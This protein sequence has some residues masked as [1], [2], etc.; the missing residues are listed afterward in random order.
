MAYP[1]LLL[2]VALFFCVAV[3]S[4]S[5]VRAAQDPFPLYDCVTPNVSFWCDIYG[6]YPSTQG[7]L[8]DKRDLRVIYEVLDVEGVFEAG[9]KERDRQRIERAKERYLD[10]LK[11]LAAGV[12]PQNREEKRVAGLFGP[13]ATAEDFRLAQDNIRFQSGQKDNFEKG[14][15]RSGAYLAEIKQIMA[16]Y[17]VPEDLA[18]LPH[19]ES[20]FNYKAY[21]KFGAAGIWQFTESSGK[22]FNLDVDYAID[23]RRDPIKAT[24][25]AA[26]M[27]RHNYEL[28]GTWPL[29][30]TAYNHGVNGMMRAKA[31]KGDYERIFQEHESELFKFASRNFYSEFLAAREVAKNYRTYFGQLPI[32]P[33]VNSKTV[34]LPNYALMNDLVKHLKVDLETFKALN[35]ALREP[36]HLGQKLIPKGYEVRVP[37]QGKA[38]RLADNIPSEILKEDQAQTN[39]YQVRQGDTAYSIALTHGITVTDL[40]RGNGLDEQAVICP[41]QNLR[42]PSLGERGTLAAVVGKK[43]EPPRP[44][45]LIPVVPGGKTAAQ[46][47][48]EVVSL[49]KLAGA[50]GSAQVVQPVKVA[51]LPEATPAK[52]PEPAKAKGAQCPSLTPAKVLGNLGIEVVKKQGKT[53][54]VVRVEAE[55][56]LG[57]YARWLGVRA[58]DLRHFNNLRYE[59]ALAVNQQIK[60]PLAKGSKEKFEAQRYEFHKEMVEDFFAA[61]RLMEGTRTYR[62][63]QGDTIW[64]LCQSEFELPFWLIKKYNESVDFT[65][66]KPGLHLVVPRV[67]SIR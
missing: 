28:L 1:R 15:I 30:V 64:S 31:A 48:G 42:I 43:T 5:P 3:V 55:E 62:V 40:L 14:L 12:P 39:M 49:V 24:H 37:Q 66:L 52:A 16:S 6:K 4:V 23:E 54:G 65:Q 32:E 34:T 56:T 60:I 57:H 25:A 26:R 10:I 36:V 41:G 47:G 51:S 50:P 29:A 9:A 27:L 61:Y 2:A 19:V 17:G 38:V 13:R 11:S 59:Q 45:G 7:V 58:W 21:S 46:S 22:Q 44:A 8:H 18:Y 53:Y 20:S 33:P 67:E 63:K 35:P